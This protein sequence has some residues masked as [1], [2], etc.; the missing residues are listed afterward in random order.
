M[1]KMNVIYPG[2]LL[3][4][5][6]LGMKRPVLVPILCI[7][8]ALLS[9]NSCAGKYEDA[10]K[11][12]TEFIKQT[13]GYLDDLGKA[14]NPKDVAKAMNNYADEMEKIWP[15]M[16]KIAEKYPELRDGEN[17]PD[18]LKDS[19]KEAE[20]MGQRMASAFRKIMPHMSDP[21]VQKAQQRLSSVMSGK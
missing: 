3:F 16:Q 19:Q 1:H 5:R 17:V 2:N 8:I 20:A 10:K 11:V 18:E 7:A 12:N 9:L 6:S 21:E 4:M 14:D 15:E 13:E